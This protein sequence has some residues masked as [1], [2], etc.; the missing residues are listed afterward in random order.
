MSFTNH[1]HY[2]TVNN[3]SVKLFAQQMRIMLSQRRYVIVRVKKRDDYVKFVDAVRTHRL[4]KMVGVYFE[5]RMTID[6][7]IL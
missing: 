5:R 7:G 3:V 1:H 2:L 6:W 4:Y